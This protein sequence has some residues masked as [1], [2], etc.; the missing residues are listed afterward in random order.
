MSA[1]TT[2]RWLS[3]SVPMSIN[4]S[5]DRVFAVR[6]RLNRILHGGSKFSVRTPEL[7]EQ[8]TAEPW[9]RLSD[10][11]GV[12]QLFH[13]VIHNFSVHRSIGNCDGDL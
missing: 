5:Y 3:S 4:K 1:P 13:V 9:I 11:D 10:I 2:S 8:H 6:S 7:L 12:H